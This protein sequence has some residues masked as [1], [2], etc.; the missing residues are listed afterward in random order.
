MQSLPRTDRPKRAR[1]SHPRA[2]LLADEVRGGVAV[3]GLPADPTFGAE[4]RARERIQPR[5]GGVVRRGG[6]HVSVSPPRPQHLA[7]GGVRP[8]PRVARP[9]RVGRVRRAGQPRPRRRRRPKGQ[10]HLKG[11]AAVGL[12]DFRVF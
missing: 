3:P 9:G 1:S 5:A 7:R 4:K 2:H 12:T 8:H 11:A 6:V 10:Q